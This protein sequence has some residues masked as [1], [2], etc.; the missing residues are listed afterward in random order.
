MI[1]CNAPCPGTEVRC[2]RE[3]GHVGECWS[4][5][6]AEHEHGVSYGELTWC[7]PN[8]LP[9]QNSST[10]EQKEAERDDGMA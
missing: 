2:Q 4:K 5:Y 7:G 3:A 10:A 9:K 6:R 1:A 8:N